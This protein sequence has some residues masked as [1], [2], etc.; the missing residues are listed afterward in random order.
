[1]Q[2]NTD[3]TAEVEAAQHK[4]AVSGMDTELGQ[5]EFLQLLVAQLQHQDPMNPMDDR[6]FIAQMAQFSTLSQMQTLARHQMTSL[7]A[8]LLGE[9]LSIQCAGGEEIEGIVESIRW[10]QDEL[11]L[12]TDQGD[13]VTMDEVSQL[14]RADPA[15]SENNGEPE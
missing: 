4:S 1:M 12:T 11:V 14:R 9:E 2:I 13:R 15:E 5:S 3:N 10:E 6:D 7:G 8:S